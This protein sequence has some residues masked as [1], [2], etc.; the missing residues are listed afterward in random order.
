MWHQNTAQIL[1]DK[2]ASVFLSLAFVESFFFF[3]EYEKE[4]QF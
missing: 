2:I 4:Q 1:P 3:L